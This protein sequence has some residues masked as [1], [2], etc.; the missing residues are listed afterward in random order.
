MTDHDH[1]D[2]RGGVV[3]EGAPATPVDC[4]ASLTGRHPRARVSAR[5]SASP[6]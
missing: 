2:V 3:F 6:R 4:D 1:I 5:A